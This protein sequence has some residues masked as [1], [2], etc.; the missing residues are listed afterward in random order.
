[1]KA[2]P[3]WHC[4]LLF[5]YCDCSYTAPPPTADGEQWGVDLANT[6]EDLSQIQAPE[7]PD[8][9]QDLEAPFTHEQLQ[10]L[11][12]S[13]DL[14]KDGKMT[15]N[16]MVEFARQKHF[17]T[18]QRDAA[19]ILE[20]IDS[21][22][23]G[24]LSLPELLSGLHPN[25]DPDEDIDDSF[26]DGP[27]FHNETEYQ[28]RIDMETKK[29]RAADKDND[30]LLDIQ[31]V[32]A[33]FFPEMSAG[34]L[35]LEVRDQMLKSDQDGDGLISM[36]EF[37]EYR[38]VSMDHQNDFEKLDGNKDGQLDLEELKNWS[39]GTYSWQKMF[40]SLFST[41]DK[42]NDGHITMDELTAGAQMGD[43]KTRFQLKKWAM[44]SLISHQ[45]F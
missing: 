6:L 16:E 38:G 27:T 7:E 14:N 19:Q 30:G 36:K 2:N 25:S 45:E 20:V 18:T 26:H 12:N 13:L 1:M 22:S 21:D 24:K 34:T 11:H 39:N 4:L 40:A 9:T 42:D 43:L 3:P 33:V 8:I 15:L 5:C 23:D 17:N 32:P 41:A 44:D 29:F 10:Q 37:E 31:E 28:D 35:E